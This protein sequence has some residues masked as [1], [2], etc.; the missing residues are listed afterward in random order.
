M[1]ALDEIRA[2]RLRK[3]ALLEE[4]GINPYPNRSSRTHEIGAVLG[5]FEALSTEASVVIVDGRIRAIRKHGGSAFLDIE[6][7]TGRMQVFLK[8]DEIGEELFTLFEDVVDTGDFIEVSGT[9]F[10]TKHGQESIQANVWRM[11]AKTLRPIPDEWYGL[12]NEDERFRRRYL[13][14]LLNPEVA[15]IARK[16]SL[17]WNSMRTY[18]LKDG[19]VEVETPVLENTTGGAEARPFETHHN[20][21][22][23]DVFLR[24][25]AGELWQKKL[26]VGGLPK[27]FEIGRIFRNEGMSREHLQDYTQLEFYQAYSDYE[28]GKRMVADLYRHIAKETFGTTTF[29]IGEHTVDLAQE[30]ETYN[31]CD[32]LKKEYDLD[33]LSAS[34]A[35]V[36]AA[37][38]KAGIEKDAETMSIER[39]V[40]LLWKKVRKTISGPG[41]LVGV[42]V[43]LEPLAKRS[44][45]NPAV[46]ERFQII[47]AGSEMGKGFSELNNPID[48]RERFMKQQALRDAGD[49]EAQMADMEFVEALEYGM[50]PAFGFGLS[51]RLF[52][53]LMNMDVR[54]AQL[55]PL[56]RPRD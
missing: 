8:K 46:V 4:K 7:G 48:Q 53:F 19:F 50:P 34:L 25:S 20:A 12:H 26:L 33:P 1:S 22:D 31:F 54:E 29:T 15:A 49:A 56:M 37:L 16:R 55:F 2:E 5:E 6:D 35:E 36:S 3:L 9:V 13:D 27:V 17:F 38:A 43:Y 45:S 44:E 32:I 11:L 30:W 40:D 21:L 52:S 39:G 41:F 23:I 10:R 14:M 51:E 18:L 24:I 42:P 28:E 47:L